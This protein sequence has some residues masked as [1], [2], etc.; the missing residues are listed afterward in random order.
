MVREAVSL[1]GHTIYPIQMNEQEQDSG[2]LARISL[3]SL[4]NLISTFA[5]ID[6][7]CSGSSLA[8]WLLAF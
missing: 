2:A 7:N 3:A 5:D 8:I 6:F 4:Q 1:A